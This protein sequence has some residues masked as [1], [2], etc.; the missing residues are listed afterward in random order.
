ML[1]LTVGIRDSV[2][3]V[4]S[5]LG[6][7]VISARAGLGS[8]IATA[9]PVATLLT[10]QRVCICVGAFVCVWVLQREET[11]LRAL[12]FGSALRLSPVSSALLL[13]GFSR[14]GVRQGY[15]GSRLAEPASRVSMLS[16]AY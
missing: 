13:Q 7:A 16:A 9:L 10:R 4:V 8:I 2:V 12:C 1:P 14:V 3:H 6:S 11:R 15:G 5:T